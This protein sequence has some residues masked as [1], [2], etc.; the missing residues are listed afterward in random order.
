[1]KPR[2]RPLITILL[3]LISLAS[4]AGSIPTPAHGGLRIGGAAQTIT[5]RLNGNVTLPATNVNVYFYK[6]LF[7]LGKSPSGQ[8]GLFLIASFQLTNLGGSAVQLAAPE[9]VQLLTQAMKTYDPI[10]IVW[11]Q[12]ASAGHQ[13]H[14]EFDF[15][16]S[17]DD[18]AK[19]IDW[20]YQGQGILVDLTST[21][22]A[23]TSAT[24]TVPLQTTISSSTTVSSYTQSMTSRAT[25]SLT[26][27]RTTSS[28]TT[29]SKTTNSLFATTKASTSSTSTTSKTSSQTGPAQTAGLPWWVWLVLGFLLLTLFII[30]FR[31]RKR[32]KDVATEIPK[33][34]TT[35]PP[36]QTTR[37]VQPSRPH[38][39]RKPQSLEEWARTVEEK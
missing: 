11:P 27:S 2:R 22:I 38:P 29:S 15:M 18:Q 9:N 8:S 3:F 5:I 21:P 1:M 4:L 28:K 19:E 7:Y 14:A 37:S 12:S 32:R 39:S 17:T 36:R 13:Y 20:S 23:T 34:V 33:R 30:L 35:Y 25:T 26:T 16:L 31:R 24:I 10:G 6:A